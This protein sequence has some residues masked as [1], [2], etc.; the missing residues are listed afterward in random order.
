VKRILLLVLLLFLIPPAGFAETKNAP[1]VSQRVYKKLKKIDKL[2][3]KSAYAEAL[4]TLQTLLP[5]LDEKSFDQ[6][7]VLRSIAAVYAQRDQYTKAAKFLQKSINTGA[8][9]EDQKNRASYNLAQFYMATEQYQKALN[10]LEPWVLAQDKPSGD[11]Y[12]LLANAYAQLKRYRKAIIYAEKAIATKPRS[13]ENWHKFLLALQYQLADYQGAVK[14]LNGLIKNF[15]PKK[16]YWIQLSSTYQQLKRYDK[17]LA[18]QELGY[19]Q[20]H[21]AD[22]KALHDLVH[23]MLHQNAPYQAAVLTENELN[24]GRIKTT[25]K[26]WELLAN[27]WT[28]AREYERAANALQK[29]S[30][31]N[32]SGELFFRLGRI[33]FEQESWEKAHTALRKAL[34]KGGLKDPGT[35]HILIGMSC[36]ELQWNG[37]AKKAFNSAKRY[38]KTRKI[39][40]QW[41]N[42]VN[43]ESS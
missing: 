16:E 19:R 4:K 21:I 41:L 25:S 5:E 20:G 38:R 33:Y 30:E 26:N 10:L 31:L 42:Y 37:K 40:Q 36:H 3:V 13:H 32:Q 17:A 8:L 22:D 6:A 23:L 35:T 14:V 34:K 43:M 12:M 27:S 15:P 29:A 24:K 28:Q 7:V 11:N 39:A 1:G 9:P 18:V 2:L